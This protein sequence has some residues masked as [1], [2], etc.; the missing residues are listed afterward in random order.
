M[1]ALVGLS[2]KEDDKLKL[3]IFLFSGQAINSVESRVFFNT[4]YEVD[5]ITLIGKLSIILSKCSYVHCM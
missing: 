1:G 3:A 2:F 4:S 5:Y